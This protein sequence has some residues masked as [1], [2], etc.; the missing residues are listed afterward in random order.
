MFHMMDLDVAAQVFE[1]LRQL[2]EF[3]MTVVMPDDASLVLREHLEGVLGILSNVADLVI[4]VY[5]DD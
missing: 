2:R 4:A 3:R 1:V 5:K